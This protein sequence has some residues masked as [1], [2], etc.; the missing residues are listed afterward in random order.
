VERFGIDAVRYYLM[1]DINISRDSNF[2]IER[3]VGTFNV[4]LANNL[5]NLCNRTLTMLRKNCGETME[6]DYDDE[7]SITLREKFTTT[8]AAYNENM[9]KYHI[10]EALRVTVEFLTEANIYAEK[11]APWSLAKDEDK[12]SQ[13]I[14]V[15]NHMLEATALGA[16]LFQP[17]IPQASGKIYN[18]LNLADIEG[19]TLDTLKWGII[20]SG[21]SLSKPK[22]VFPRIQL[23]E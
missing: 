19:L 11:Q 8:L 10:D 5:G 17:V 6:S 2:D 1:R 18:Q 7:L 23:E 20:P 21:H 4:E 13:L 3:L 16:I 12:K 15:L 14:T 22:P 9:E